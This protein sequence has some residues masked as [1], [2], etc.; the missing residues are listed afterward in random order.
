M[1]YLP[2]YR[3]YALDY[4]GERSDQYDIDRLASML[5]DACDGASPDGMDPDDFTDLLVECERVRTRVEYMVEWGYDDKGDGDGAFF[6]AIEDARRQYEAEVS[7][8]DPR[9]YKTVSLKR[10]ECAY[11]D[12]W[13][14]EV[15][16]LE[17]IEQVRV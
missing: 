5:R 17:T 13:C 15:R 16:E 7:R 4:T 10:V 9:H 1:M 3:D 12:G 14:V 8:V 2:D 6:D 11:E